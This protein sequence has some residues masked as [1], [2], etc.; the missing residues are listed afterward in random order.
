MLAAQQ[1]QHQHQQ[2]HIL[3]HQQQQVVDHQGSKAGQE[4]AP[5]AGRSVSFLTADASTAQRRLLSLQS[6]PSATSMRPKVCTPSCC[7]LSNDAGVPCTS[8]MLEMENVQSKQARQIQS[9]DRIFLF[10]ISVL[11]FCASL[12][13]MH[14]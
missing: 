1:H 14:Q 12:W 2:H 10:G 4:S 13:R 7:M 11:R 6:Q 8:W 3:Q 9:S 5:V